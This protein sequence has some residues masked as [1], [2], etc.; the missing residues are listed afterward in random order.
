VSC[1]WGFHS[2]KRK[3]N[4]LDAL[5]D[6]HARVSKEETAVTALSRRVST[7]EA[8]AQGTYKGDDPFDGIP[9]GL[10]ITGLVVVQLLPFLVDLVRQCRSS[11]SSGL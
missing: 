3:R 2:G 7:L 6:L 1:F 5:A 10:I 4:D 11:S 8:R 9:W